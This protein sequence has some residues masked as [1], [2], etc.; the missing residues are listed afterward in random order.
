MRD[1]CD[2][3]PRDPEAD[4]LGDYIARLERQRDRAIFYARVTGAFAGFVLTIFLLD[5]P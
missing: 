1:P 5:A 4:A 3:T 2:P